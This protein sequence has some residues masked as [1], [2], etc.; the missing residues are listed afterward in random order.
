MMHLI[1]F[2]H[3]LLLSDVVGVRVHKFDPEACEW[4]YAF[5]SMAVSIRV[6]QQSGL[7]TQWTS[8]GIGQA[9][10][11]PGEFPIPRSLILQKWQAKIFKNNA[12]NQHESAQAQLQPSKTHLSSPS[13]HS[14]LLVPV[15][16]Q[17]MTIA[18]GWGPSPSV[19]IAI[20]HLSCVW[21][22]QFLA[23]AP[24]F[25]LGNVGK[26]DTPSAPKSSL[27]SP[28]DSPS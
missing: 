5:K 8:L 12:Q 9:R 24:H 1:A 18:Q 20:V 11:L 7:P 3:Q 2:V 27:P 10:L 21:K 22:T 16:A 6:F 14:H 23:P 19:T 15:G 13:S 25:L 26:T 4:F 28:L 17:L